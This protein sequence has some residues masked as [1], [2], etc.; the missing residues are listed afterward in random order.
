MV[1]Y[2]CWDYIN[3]KNKCILWWFKM[4]LKYYSNHFSGA[5]FPNSF[6]MRF[7]YTALLFCVYVN[8]FEKMDTVKFCVLICTWSIV[9][10]INK[11]IMCGV[12]NGY[13][14]LQIIDNK[15]RPEQ[16]M[17]PTLPAAVL[18]R[19]IFC[20]LST[21]SKRSFEK[22]ALYRLRGKGSGSRLYCPLFHNLEKEG[23]WMKVE[24]YSRLFF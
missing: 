6:D 11:N 14:F 21:S 7:L 13:I 18:H 24:Y 22:K 20:F 12:Q 8:Q 9:V 3:Y 1:W 19:M 10:D 16:K 4:L 15:I 2:F 23:L 17:H 5:D